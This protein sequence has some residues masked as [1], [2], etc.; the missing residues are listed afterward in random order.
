MTACDARSAFLALKY[1]KG[2]ASAMAAG[3]WD[4]A[5]PGETAVDRVRR[6]ADGD[7]SGRGSFLEALARW[8]AAGCLKIE[9]LLRTK[10]DLALFSRVRR[11]LPAWAQDAL[12][13][14]S[15]EAL[16][17]AVAPFAEAASRGAAL[18]SKEAK[19]L[20]SARMRSEEHVEILV[21]A[22]GG[23]VLI[24][25]T[26]EAAKH[27]GRG[28]RWCT[29]MEGR[30]NAFESYARRGALVVVRLADGSAFQYHAAS[31]SCCDAADM[32]ASPR[33]VFDKAPFLA[34]SRRAS[35]E[36]WMTAA[37]ASPEDKEALSSL[38]P[39]TEAEWMWAVSVDGSRL[40]EVP[41]AMLTRELCEAARLRSGLN[42]V[43]ETMRDHR[44]CSEAAA[45]D[46]SEMRWIPEAILDWGICLRAVEEGGL[47]RTEGHFAGRVP[48][49]LLTEENLLPL[50]VRHPEVLRE[51]P[52]P[53]MTF[54]I[55]RAAARADGTCVRWI[56]ARRRSL[57]LMRAAVASSPFAAAHLP[58]GPGFDALRLAAV[59]SNFAVLGRID[60]GKITRELA[61]A[62]YASAAERDWKGAEV[63]HFRWVPEGF[64]DVE[65]SAVLLRRTGGDIPR[66]DPSTIRRVRAL[67][68]AEAFLDAE[69]LH[70]GADGVVL[71]PKNICDVE[72]LEGTVKASYRWGAYFDKPAE[73]DILFFSAPGPSGARMRA[74]VCRLN[75]VLRV[76]GEEVPAVL[77]AR[78]AELCFSAAKV[79]PKR[80][81]FISR[82]RVKLSAHIDSEERAEIFAADHMWNLH[83]IPGR[84]LTARIAE[85]A[86][87]AELSSPWEIE[88]KLPGL[89]SPEGAG[90]CAARHWDSWSQIPPRL[91]CAA[92]VEAMVAAKAESFFSLPKSRRTKK[93]L[94]S[95]AAG[96]PHLLALF[97]AGFDLERWSAWKWEQEGIRRREAENQEPQE[98]PE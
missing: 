40:S 62:A 10:D 64:F 6:L 41:L 36:L 7:P 70:E 61:E 44:M 52:R 87:T 55:E 67:A 32:N 23:L 21:D 2:L 14:A 72:L 78:F 9:D 5:G 48:G 13:L 56:P 51:V 8:H 53:W 91:R 80:H 73:H 47:L 97:E 1:A 19:R 95:A 46:P 81:E 29:S 58:E 74:A 12:R 37:A 77:D 3:A 50:A 45:A 42:V 85:A 26:T 71:T 88:E 96:A 25:K 63:L 54:R 27:W 15:P 86:A 84:F 75:S 92:A 38:G 17:L 93:V 18:S 30:G 16:Y 49:H 39:K 89:L 66:Q 22:P 11:R 20:E 98:H 34:R 43:P 79:L 33:I 35:V 31:R 68:E 4:P 82:M 69:I 90:R 60:R 24:L 94:A 59:R 65:K 57:P 83:H 76:H 28:T